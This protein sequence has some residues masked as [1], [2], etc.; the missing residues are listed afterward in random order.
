MFDLETATPTKPSL[1][2]NMLPN[3][4]T[5]K[6]VWS[7]FSENLRIVA[8]KVSINSILITKS[9]NLQFFL[10]GAGLRCD[11]DIFKL[12]ASAQSVYR[13]VHGI[14]FDINVNKSISLFASVPLLTCSS[15]PGAASS[16]LSNL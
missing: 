14:A 11:V 6:N 12:T 4:T 9:L 3:M 13:E 1:S 16:R 10:Y 2:G 15:P 8:L 5:C 7:N